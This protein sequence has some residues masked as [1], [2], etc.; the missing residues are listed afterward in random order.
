MGGVA[1]CISRS[2]RVLADLFSKIRDFWHGETVNLSI[3]SII[4][5]AATSSCVNHFGTS[6]LHDYEIKSVSLAFM[7]KL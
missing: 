5:L 7:S 1:L 6:Y 3:F 2:L 4:T